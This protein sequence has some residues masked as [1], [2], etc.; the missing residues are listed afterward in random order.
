MSKHNLAV[1][2]KIEHL[3]G[4]PKARP[5]DWYI[6]EALQQQY[7]SNFSAPIFEQDEVLP[8]IPEGC[9]EPFGPEFLTYKMN[10][11]Q[12]QQ[13]QEMLDG[14]IASVDGVQ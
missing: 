10:D 8:K 12:E 11:Q 4:K 13:L 1:E 5:R 3:P 9:S 2:K 14:V 6:R 7:G